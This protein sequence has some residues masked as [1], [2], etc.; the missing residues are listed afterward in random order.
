MLDF[1]FNHPDDINFSLLHLN[2][3][4]SIINFD[5]FTQLLDATQHKFSAIGISETWLNDV[6]QNDKYY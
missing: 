1:P 4:S 6:N 3:C 5:N 2:A